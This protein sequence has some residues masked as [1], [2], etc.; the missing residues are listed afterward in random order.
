MLLS[1]AWP[2]LGQAY[3]GEGRR[4]LR[5]AM[6]PLLALLAVGVLVVLLGPAV[7]VAYLLVPAYAALAGLAVLAAALWWAWAILDAGRVRTNG[8]VLAGVAMLAVVGLAAG[9][10]G[11]VVLSLYQAGQGISRPIASP[12]PSPTASGLPTIA[13]TGPLGPTLP[14][15]DP[16]PSP[17]PS[18]QLG[19]RIT[20]LFLGWDLGR[21]VEGQL[22]DTIQV[23]SFDPDTG[24]IAVISLPRDTGQLPLYGGGTWP[25]KVNELMA[26]AEAHPDEFPDGGLGTLEREL[27]YIIGIPIDYYAAIDFDGFR[28]IV[29]LVGGVDVVLDR[30]IADH[31]YGWGPDRPRGFFLEPGEHHLDGRTALAYA[32]S[33]KGPGNNDWQRARRQQQILLA[34]RHKVNDPAILARLPE[35]VE[36]VSRMV[37][38]N[39][40][41]EQVPQIVSILQQSTGAD[42]QT[43]VLKP[44]GYAKVIPR[45]EIGRVYMT[46]LKMDVVAELSVELFG[47]ESRYFEP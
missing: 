1:L 18:P 44:P 12:S 24:Q 14:P 35:L 33:R 10:A 25:R 5:F 27:E 20:V 37:R 22:T 38:T 15:T 17:S 28:E 46:R 34:L 23:A 45:S 41:I 4:G 47:E 36:A 3:R 30:P 16:P 43:Y 40:P 8:T 29:D 6:L 7:F 11:S 21:G 42:A 2:G 26:Y 19:G 39:A 9:W 13:P 32:R 31:T